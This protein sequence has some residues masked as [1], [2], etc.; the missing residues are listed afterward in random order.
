MTTIATAGAAGVRSATRARRR[1]GSASNA[2][3]R[4]S[5]PI[6]CTAGFRV[7]A[8]CG[9]QVVHVSVTAANS[10]CAKSNQYTDAQTSP[11]ASH[12]STLALEP[13]T[14]TVQATAIFLP[15]SKGRENLQRLTLCHPTL[16]QLNVFGGQRRQ[17]EWHSRYVHA[18]RATRFLVAS[19][20]RGDQ[21]WRTVG[22]RFE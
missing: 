8:A 13:A 15:L 18:W 3:A 22:E 19:E 9:K 10:Q 14:I 1:M 5:S 6:E 21:A 2:L 17:A 20:E 4:A 16:D 11:P 7:P 12:H